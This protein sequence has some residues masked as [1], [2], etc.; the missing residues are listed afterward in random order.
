MEYY[1]NL[2]E[3][4]SDARFHTDFEKPCPK[5]AVVC[6]RTNQGDTKDCGG[7]P[8]RFTDGE[9]GPKLGVTVEVVDGDAG[10]EKEKR[11][12][13]IH[14]NCGPDTEPVISE[15]ENCHYTIRY[16]NLLAC[17]RTKTHPK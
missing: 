17:P 14:V 2:C 7:P 3:T 13:T 6:Q 1:W 5:H 10:C 4:I 15:D 8:F 16:S 12:T 9:K 11:S